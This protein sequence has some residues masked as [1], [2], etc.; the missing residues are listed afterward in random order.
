MQARDIGSR[1]RTRDWLADGFERH[2][3]MGTPHQPG[4]PTPSCATTDDDLFSQASTPSPS[5]KIGKSNL[6]YRKPC[7][8][9]HTSDEGSHGAKMETAYWASPEMTVRRGGMPCEMPC[10]P[11]L[12][13]AT[14]PT[15]PMS[16][17]ILGA[18]AAPQLLLPRAAS[19]FSLRDFQRVAID[20]DWLGNAP[21]YGLMRSLHVSS[22]TA[23]VYDDDAPRCTETVATNACLEFG[24]SESAQVCM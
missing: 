13:S 19:S 5:V 10:A 14:S 6:G 12:N 8:V 15:R 23:S 1:R 9:E 21:I 4:T 7:G 22:A 17:L 11:T 20:L 18:N 16:P 24:R 2:P 3:C